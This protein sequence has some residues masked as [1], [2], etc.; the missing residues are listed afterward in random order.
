ML[1]FILKWAILSFILI[2][3]I[4]YLYSFFK[5]TLTI[6]KVRDLVNKPTERYNEM[7]DTIK[8]NHDV[9]YNEGVKYNDKNNISKQ[10]NMQDEL[11]NFL[12]DLKKN[13][14]V[15]SEILSSNDGHSN[16]FSNY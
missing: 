4:H 13:K 10:D 9:K 2:V 5:T 12:Q 14:N 6:P 15:S 16:T 7:I 1:L 8:Y 11:S 3:L